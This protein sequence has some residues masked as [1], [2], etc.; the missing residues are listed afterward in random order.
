[1]LQ[2]FISETNTYSRIFAPANGTRHYRN[3]AL[4]LLIGLALAIRITEVATHQNIIWPDE[5]Y[6]TLE[7]A[8]HLV[9]G[10]WIRSWEWVV[11][12]RSWLVPALLAGPLWL[13]RLLDPS[14]SAGRLIVTGLM[15]LL[16]LIPVL[17]GFLFGERV[18]GTAGGL[19][20]GGMAAIWPDLIYMA[21]HPLMDVFASH[22]LLVA[23]YLAVPLTSTSPVGR[24]GAAG[25]LLGLAIYLRMQL[26]PAVA[27][28]ALLA[29]G[30]SIERWRALAVSSGVALV[31]LGL[32][33]WATL[34]TPFQSLWL[35]FWFNIVGKVSDEFGVAGPLFY[36]SLS[37][38]L[39]GPAVVAVFL[40]LAFNYRQHFPLLVVLLTIV[41]TQSLISHKEWRFIFPALSILPI[42]LG[43][44]LLDLLPR[45][46]DLA[47]KVGAPRPAAAI[48]LA[49][50]MIGMAVAIGS[51]PTFS[52]ARSHR[53]AMLQAF[54]ALKRDPGVCGVGL[55]F[56]KG[57]DADQS[58][59]FGPGSTA[60]PPGTPLYAALPEA[61][62]KSSPSYN[63]AVIE[64]E[65]VPPPP[66]RLVS[67]AAAGSGNP[68]V[69]GA[70]TCVWRRP[71]GCSRAAAE[72]LKVN[73][74]GYF[75]DDSGRVRPDRVSPRV[76]GMRPSPSRPL[77]TAVSDGR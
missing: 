40:I 30:R 32:F 38:V 70:R 42:L 12:M 71:G 64:D 56:L 47:D 58:W 23:L 11:G 15:L 61:G 43:L 16:A 28:I 33:D 27:V 59:V 24:L 48:G 36:V 49:I 41:A 44:R 45:L 60:L 77:A 22:V 74:P 62:W 53:G 21:P 66:F 2:R 8:H 29:A 3:F 10:E 5:I 1:M 39:W 75:L 34:G 76:L 57:Q 31:V 17:V 65:E 68:L 9:F 19:I 35:N 52:G 25:A 54:G 26:G 63:A 51:T 14:G 6:Q 73:W 69:R 55:L 7:P 37:E 13:G 4:V 18:K 72:P 50:L 67:C 46:T 20:V